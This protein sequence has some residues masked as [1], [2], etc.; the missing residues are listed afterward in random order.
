MVWENT[1]VY[2]LFCTSNNVRTPPPPLQKNM[3]FLGGGGVALLIFQQI[4]L[5]KI[6]RGRGDKADPIGKRGYGYCP[7]QHILY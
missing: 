3:E 2:S 5:W 7:G 6:Q 1:L 4:M